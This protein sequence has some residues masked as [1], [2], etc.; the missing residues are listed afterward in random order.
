MIRNE[1]PLWEQTTWLFLFVASVGL[2]IAALMG[3]MYDGIRDFLLDH[4]CVYVYVCI[5]VYV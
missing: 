3:M 5:H 2:A 1:L 4:G